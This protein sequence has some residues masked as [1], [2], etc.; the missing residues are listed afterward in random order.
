MRADGTHSMPATPTPKRNHPVRSA[1]FVNLREKYNDNV[2]V[3][4]ARIGPSE[5]AKMLTIERMSRIRSRFHS[6][7]FYS[8]LAK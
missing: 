3:L 7:Q 5:V 2:I 8:S 1:T 6:G 4:A